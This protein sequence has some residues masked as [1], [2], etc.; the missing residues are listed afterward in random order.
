[1]FAIF[2]LY[3]ET[4][5]DLK[6]IEQSK[7]LLCGKQ[8]SLEV[9]GQGPG[10]HRSCNLFPAQSMVDYVTVPEASSNFYILVFIKSFSVD[11]VNHPAQLLTRSDL[12][13]VGKFCLTWIIVDSVHDLFPSYTVSH[14]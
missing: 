1:M 10:L 3:M 11:L 12:I 5:F 14:I 13:R 7:F 6:K 9:T 4:N 8:L 2:N